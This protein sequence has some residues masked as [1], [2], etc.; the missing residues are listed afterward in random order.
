MTRASQP[1]AA[2]KTYYR[3]I[4]AAIRWCGLL[5]FERR[6]LSTLAG[7]ALPDDSEFR[8][9]P[10]LRLNTERILDALAHNEL[11]RYV[12]RQA[13]RSPSLHINA[14]SDPALI[15]RH[16]DLRAWMARYYPG[17]KPSFLFDEIERAL[18]PA[19]TQK[20]LGILLAERDAT[21]ARLDELSLVH[22]ALFVE[23]EA[24][25]KAYAS[26]Q[27]KTENELA[28]GPRS[29]STYLNIIGGL[30]SL[31][32]GKSPSGAAYSSFRT[33]ESVISALLAHHEHLPGISERTLWS[34]LAQARRH[35][36]GSN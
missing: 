32:L 25:A 31:L 20:S 3:P 34:K 16:V 28:P 18:H 14:L 12:A 7:R 2:A 21:R 17:E 35:L 33:M 10:T 9:W 29:E 8:R 27:R 19:I 13:D 4:E 22:K 36:D 15:V 30:L 11:P 1:P 26:R 23:H 6:I 24:L 5:Q